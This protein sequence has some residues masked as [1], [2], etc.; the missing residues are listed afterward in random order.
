MTVKL[1][2]LADG[3]ILGIRQ[4]LGWASASG[5]QRLQPS[6]RFALSSGKS[7]AAALPSAWAE[8][9]I[10]QPRPSAVAAR[11]PLPLPPSPPACNALPPRSLC[12]AILDGMRWPGLAAHMAARYRQAAGGPPAEASELLHP[13]DR[14]VLSLEHYC[15]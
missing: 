14:S 8:A 3:D 4:V 2:R 9:L 5:K 10:G 11:P 12:H 7:T 13:I 15:Q 1:T 6:V